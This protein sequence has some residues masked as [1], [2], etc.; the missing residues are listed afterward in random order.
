MPTINAVTPD[1]QQYIAVVRQENVAKE[2]KIMQ[3]N[4]HSPHVDYQ[5]MQEVVDRSL[6]NPN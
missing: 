2:I 1:R 6:T 5:Y 4:Q 3:I